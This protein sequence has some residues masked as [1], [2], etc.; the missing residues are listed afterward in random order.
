MEQI[1][2]I[3]GQRYIIGLQWNPLSG[4]DPLLAARTMAK[5][6]KS[7]LGL[8]RTVTDSDGH[9]VHQVGLA[10]KKVKGIILAAAAQIA[11]ISKSAIAISQLSGELYWL[12]ITDNGRVL[13]GYDRIGNAAE[14]IKA[15]NEFEEDYQ[16]SYMQL[17]M[18]TEVAKEL[19]IRHGVENINPLDILAEQPATDAIKLKNLAGLSNTTMLGAAIGIL[20]VGGGG[21]W[22]YTEELRQ[23]AIEEQLA[24]E[25]FEAESRE[26][27]RLAGLSKGPTDEEILAQARVEEVTWLRDSFNSHSLINALKHMYVMSSRMPTQQGGWTLDNIVFNGSNPNELRTTWKR[28]GGTLAGI[29]QGLEG[30]GTVSFS[31]DFSQASASH[32]ISL[33]NRGIEDIEHFIPERGMRQHEL[34]DLF[35]AEGFP[36]TISAV[37]TTQRSTNIKGLKD[38]TLENVPQLFVKK[39]SFGLSGKNKDGYVKLMSLLQNVENMTPESVEVVRTGGDFSWKFT[40][41]LQDL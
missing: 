9:V 36:F 27:A 13:P 40:G 6:R 19:R 1:L 15:V 35:I 16:V 33:G 7:S 14:I 5:A 29:K 39:W 21:Y 34:V 23:R 28:N 37:T 31:N 24:L 4:A 18:T 10:Q 12:C 3:G 30:Q 17:L 25:A 41:I 20:L 26:K 2:E 11:T 38:K 8:L 32:K 22:K